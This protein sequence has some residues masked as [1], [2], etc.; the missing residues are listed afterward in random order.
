MSNVVTAVV[1]GF[2]VVHQNGHLH[3]RRDTF[4]YRLHA[5]E[6]TGQVT[7]AA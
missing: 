2:R 6:S 3:G 1:R 4:V 5:V 7:V